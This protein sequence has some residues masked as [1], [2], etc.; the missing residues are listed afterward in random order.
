MEDREAIWDIQHNFTQVKSFLTKLEAFYG[1]M[2]TLVD[3]G[4]ATDVDF[5]KIFDIVAS[6]NS[7]L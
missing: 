1:G 5:S 3:K 2:I 7:S 4:R 6:Q